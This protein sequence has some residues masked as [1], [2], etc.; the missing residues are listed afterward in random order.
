MPGLPSV[1]DGVPVGRGVR[2]AGRACP[3]A[4]RERVSAAVRLSVARKFFIERLL[5]FPARIT[6]TAKLLRFYQRSGLQQLSRKTGLLKLLGL[7]D[8]EKLLP[9]ID[10]RFFFDQLGRTFPARG[11]RRARV[12][13]FAG[14]IANVSFTKLNE[15]TIRVLTANG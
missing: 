4:N 15:A 5:P 10:E 6:F 2:K 8:R 12:A 14:C 3:G 13:F 11:Q 7:A 9:A 1:R